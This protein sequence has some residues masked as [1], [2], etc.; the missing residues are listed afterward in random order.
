MPLMSVTGGECGALMR[1]GLLVEAWVFATGHL[2][3]EVE[4]M[5]PRAFRHCPSARGRFVGKKQLKEAA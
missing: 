1:I 2:E 4:E 5:T 3:G